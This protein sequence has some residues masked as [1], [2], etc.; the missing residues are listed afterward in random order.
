[1]KPQALLRPFSGNLAGRTHACADRT[2]TVIGRAGVEEIT[3]ILDGTLRVEHDS[4]ALD[5]RAGQAVVTKPGEW[6]RYTAPDVG[7]AEYVATWYR[8]FRWKALTAT[9]SP[10][11]TQP[12]ARAYVDQSRRPLSRSELAS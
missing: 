8:R 5:V 6:V 9:S 11:G 1:M 7:G 2:S 12:G 10:P 3:L 4:G